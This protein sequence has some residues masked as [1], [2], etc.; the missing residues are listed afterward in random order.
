MNVR[1][2]WL[3]AMLRIAGPVLE[4][5]A[6]DRLK[7]R[8]PAVFHPDRA[9]YQH[10]EALGRTA[11]GLA[12]WLELEQVPEEERQLQ[13]RW[14][15][16]TR[17]AI[18]NA[19]DPEAKDYMNFTEGYGQALVDAAFLGHAILRAPKQLYRL[20]PEKTREQLA[21]AL[22]DTRRFTPYN[23]N[24]LF[25][26]AMIEAALCVM[27]QPYDL[28]RMEYALRMFEGWYVGDG[29][30]GDGPRFHWDYY[31][32]FVIQPMQL[33]ILR[34]LHT[35]RG[36]YER[37][38]ALAEKRAARYAAVQEQLIGPDGSF[39]AI[40]RSMVYR[41]GAFQALSQAVL[42]GFLP[43]GLAYGQVR[44]GLTAVLRK[45]MEA[46]GMFDAQGWLQPGVYG[47]QPSMAEPY[48]CVGSLY[49]CCAVFLPLGLPDAHPFWQEPDM[50]WTAK[51][52]WSGTDTPCDHASDE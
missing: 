34:T 52:I 35:F 16:L 13:E 37:E 44:S 5:L 14:R 49:M 50:P 26:S 38:L 1:T 43:E 28:L 24:W 41:F 7:E 39:L 6:D 10:L 22:T 18:A 36:G 9:M 42:Q 48:I 23:S 20:L 19:V 21:R 12:P 2:Q 31:N 8:M 32:S 3:E 33:D 47:C 46:P 45:V 40:G 29:T 27:G 51:K 17:R 30:Y 25:F 4:N 11:L 15:T